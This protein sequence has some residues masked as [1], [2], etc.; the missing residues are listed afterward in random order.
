MRKEEVHTN[1]TELYAS[2]D[3]FGVDDAG[4]TYPDPVIEIR[5]APW[6]RS[7]PLIRHLFFDSGSS[8]IPSRYRQ[9][10]NREQTHQFNFDSLVSVTPISLHHQL[11]NVL[12][13]RLRSR[14]EV[15][16]TIVGT[17]TEDEKAQAALPIERAKSVQAYLTD[18]W[19]I[20]RRRM[21]VTS[22][23]PT[24]PSSEET[25]DG[26]SENRRVEFVFDGESLLRP[27]VVERLASVASPPEIR[28]HTNVDDTL[29]VADWN[30]T[31]QQG[32]KVLLRFDQT[33][34]SEEAADI[35]P[36]PLS[37]LRINRDLTP[38]HY[39]FE[40]TDVHGQKG[41]DE[42]SFRVLERVTRTSEKEIEA[43]LEVKEYLLSGFTY[44]TAE[45]QQGHKSEI[46]EI[47]RTAEEGAWIEITG[48]T[49]RVGDDQRNRELAL[50][51]ARKVEEALQDV[52]TRLSLPELSIT[53][54]KGS[55]E[56]STE[57]FDNNLPEGRI[58]SRM[59]RITVNRQTKQ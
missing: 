18:V 17:S 27:V 13:Q 7:I 25:E 14:P 15:S 54:V 19:G 50:E 34:T 44:N 20:D 45:L 8:A 33:T 29:S 23:T 39:R 3:V 55:S 21:N 47:A 48:F 1:L 42:G 46:Y 58:F 43:K 5:E 26:R 41:V 57:A 31:V 10:K 59:V 9:L 38:I 30:I 2:I 32:G 6:S 28:F 12:G 49:D 24:N 35:K 51:R 22:G 56:S 37:D 16:V 4:N 36:W 53:N 11:L 52:R 40:V